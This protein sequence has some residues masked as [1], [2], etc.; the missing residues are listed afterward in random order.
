MTLQ[1][2]DPLALLPYQTGL[3]APPLVEG[4]AQGQS[5]LD[6]PQRA[7]VLGEPLPALALL[8]GGFRMMV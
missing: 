8:K 6:S 2:S 1:I 7:I 5:L 4:A 3:V